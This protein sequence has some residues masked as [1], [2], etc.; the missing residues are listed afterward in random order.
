M[1]LNSEICD[2][3][4][5][6]LMMQCGNEEQKGTEQVQL[7]SITIITN[8]YQEREL[9]TLLVSFPHLSNGDDSPL[10]HKVTMKIK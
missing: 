5:L 1:I 10:S 8:D 9:N 2:N 7:F 6:F 4:Q 3:H